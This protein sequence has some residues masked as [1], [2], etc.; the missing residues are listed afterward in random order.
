MSTPYGGTDPQQQ[1][2]QPGYGQQPGQPQQYAQQPQYGQAPGGYGQPQPGQFQPAQ[3]QSAQPQ[4]GQQYPGQAAPQYAAPQYAGQQHGAP[5]GYGQ[6]QPAKKGG[7]GLLIG[8][9]AAVVVVAAFCVTAFLAPGFLKTTVLSQSAVQDGVKQV[10]IGN[11]Q[12]TE[13]GDVQCPAD[14]EVKSGATFDCSAVVNGQGKTVTVTIKD[15]A[16]NY[17]VAYPR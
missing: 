11:Y 8:L 17:E 16:A 13:V 9:G 15:D 1:W 14:Q 10:L 5:G 12:L 6:Q 2:S 4:Y 3:P 7:K